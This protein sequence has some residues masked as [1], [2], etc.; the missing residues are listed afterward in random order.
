M[1]LSIL[2]GRVIDPTS[3][4]DRIEDLFLSDG[5]VSGVASAPDGFVSERVIDASDKIVCPGL[6]DIAVRLGE[7]GEEYRATLER[8]LRAAVAGGITSLGCPPDTTPVLDQPGLVTML[9]DRA[10]ALNSAKIFPVGAMTQSL[11]GDYLAEMV[12]L[13]QAGCV[14]FSQGDSVL[15][16]AGV[17]KRVME[18]ASTFDF[19]IWLR[20]QE[21]FLSHNGVIHEGEVATRLGLSGIPTIAETMAVSIILMLAKETGASIHLCRLSSLSAVELV[22]LAKHEGVKVTCDVAINNLHLSDIDIG[23]FDTNYRLTPPL[24]STRDREGLRAGLVDNS[25][26][27]ICSNHSPVKYDYKKLPLEESY[28]GASG[29]EMLL[30]LTLQWAREEGI[31]LIVALAKVTSAPRRILGNSERKIAVGEIAD[32]CIFDPEY[33]W[34]VNDNSILSSGKNTPFWDSELVGR[35]THTI[36]DGEVVFTK[37]EDKSL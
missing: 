34:I 9:V 8:E 17:L 25:V 30:P 11:E 37:D 12:A 33:P 29:V 23:F 22:R 26:D 35:V 1:K 16:N 19:S 32:L 3:G 20:P 36:I 7:S 18:Y 31:P 13:K 6:V 28:S 24:R 4:F 15:P 21:E 27:L 14:A 10:G 2:N 5:M